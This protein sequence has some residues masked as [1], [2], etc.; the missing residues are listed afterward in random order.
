MQ[1]LPIAIALHH[2]LTDCM[3]EL[4][5]RE[6]AAVA[7]ACANLE[8]LELTGAGISGPAFSPLS[9]LKML[10][11]LK[12]RGLLFDQADSSTLATLSTLT[13]LKELRL[14]KGLWLDLPWNP[15]QEVHL[16]DV[17]PCLRGMRSLTSLDLSLGQRGSSSR[18]DCMQH[19]SVLQS[20]PDLRTLT[21]SPAFGYS[22]VLSGEDVAQIALAT[23][24]V[25]LR[26]DVLNTVIGPGAIEALAAMPCLKELWASGMEPGADCSRI[27]CAW[28]QLHLS[29]CP[30]PGQLLWLPLHQTEEINLPGMN[31]QTWTFRSP[32][33]PGGNETMTE[34]EVRAAAVLLLTR[35]R[36][37]QYPS[38]FW[39]PRLNIS[40]VG[41]GSLIPLPGAEPL[42]R[43]NPDGFQLSL[44]ECPLDSSTMLFLSAALPQL[45]NLCLESCH[46]THDILAAMA[47]LKQLVK[48]TLIGCRINAGALAMLAASVSLEELALVAAPVRPEE[49]ISLAAEREIMCGAPLCI[50]MGRKG[51]GEPGAMSED[52]LRRCVDSVSAMQ[53]GG[54]KPRVRGRVSIFPQVVSLDWLMSYIR[55]S[56]H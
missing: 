29:K 32:D 35:L 14:G 15:E 45:R 12:I 31:P 18:S 4:G 33:D 51:N 10:R 5:F 48:L 11:Q 1:P 24:L 47:L 43:C 20:L 26:F 56:P 54:G 2:L 8:T 37:H 50:F 16:E 27:P 40:C 34:A 52:E 55:L 23:Q 17:L 6:F 22:F 44:V 53:A 28:R 19:F 25:T 46:L 36:Y 13:Q 39:A 49:V 38:A 30:S 9:R 7:M 3:Q 42:L 21:W 41:D